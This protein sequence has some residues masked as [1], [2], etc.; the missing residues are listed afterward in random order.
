[1]A[2][3]P[4]KFAEVAQLTALGIDQS[5]M[6]WNSLTMESDKHICV[7]QEG[8]N[9]SVKISIVDLAN[10]TQVESHGINADSAIL[11]PM[12]EIIALKAETGSG[13]VLQIFN[14]KVK[15]RMKHHTITDNDKVV[16]W[17][18]IT[19]AT[20]A[21]VTNTAVYHWSME[22][23][24]KPAKVFDRDAQLAGAHILGYKIS[25]DEKW[26]SVYGIKK[27][28]TGSVDGCMQ[29]HS[30]DRNKST[31]L[32]GHCSAFATVK[33]DGAQNEVTVVAFAQ[34]TAAG[35]SQVQ[36]VEVGGGNNP[37]FPRVAGTI[38][39]ED[40]SDFPTSI[41]VS[42]KHTC[43]YMMSKMGHV[44]IYDLLTATPIFQSR[45]SESALFV[46]AN[47]EASGG[48]IGVNRNG[49]VLQIALDEANIVN[50]ICQT[51]N[52]VELAVKFA[53]RNNLPGAEGLFTRQFDALFN[54]QRFKEAA[55]C[56]A[57]SPMGVL[58]TA[59][60]IRKFQALPAT[61]G[62]SPILQYFSTLLEH[63]KLNALETVELARPA[64][65]QGKLDMLRKWWDADKLEGSEELGDM[66]RQHDNQW[67]MKIYIKGKSHSKVVAA[68]LE[69][70]QY[71]KVILYA[72]K[73]DY[74]P[75][76]ITFLR[77]MVMISPKGALDFAMKLAQNEGGSLVDIGQVVDLFMSRNLVQETTEFLLEVLKNNKPEE[78]PL[79][80]R[81]L[82]IN[83]QMAPQ[84][85]NAIFENDMFS[86]Y[87]RPH[88]ARLCEQAGLYQRALEH[89]TELSDVKRVIVHTNMIPPEVLINYFG[90][91]SAEFGLECL[92]TLL[93]TNPQGNAT[94]C[95][96][97]ATKFSEALGAAEIIPLFE[98]YNCIQGMFYYLQA[99]VNFS[100]D[101][102]VHFK[103]IQ[104]G[105]K[106][107]QLPEV[108][109][110]TRESNCYDPVAVRDFLMEAR[111]Q[112]QLPLINVCDKHDM[113]EDLVK[114]LYTNNML[115]FIQ[116]YVTDMNPMSAPKVAA[117][118]LDCDCSE[119]V[120][121]QIIT[122]VRNRCNG[123]ELV[124]EVEKRNRLKILK[125]WLE[126]VISEGNQ[127]PGVHNG[128]MKVYVDTGNEPEKYLAENLFYDS[129]D[130]GVYCEKRDPYLAFICYKRGQCD[131]ELIEVTTK[132]NLFRHQA[133]YLVERQ[134]SELWARVLDPEN[135]MR[136]N[137]IDQVISTALPATENPDD[138]S[139]TVR[140]FMAADLPGQLIE[141]LEKIVIQN[142]VFSEDPNLQ[143]LLLLTAIKAD[144]TRVMDY[145]NRL[146]KYDAPDIALIAISADLYEEAFT[147]YNKFS[148][149][150]EC[151]DVI[152]TQMTDLDRAYEYAERIDNPEVWSRLGR[153]QMQACN[154]KGAVESFCKA[155]DAQD[156]TNM[157]EQA[158]QVEAWEDLVTYLKMARSD[159]GLNKEP[160]VDTELIYALAK[161]NELAQLEE[162]INSP[163]VAQIQ[164]VG[165][166][167][168]D[169]AMY[170]AAKLLFLNISNY[171]RLAS[172]RVMLGE[173]QAA[174][175]A[176]KKAMSPRTWKEVNFA[177]VDAEEFKL[178]QVCGLHIIVHADELDDLINK[179]EHG[180]HFEQLIELMEAGTGLERAHMGIYTELGILYA[181]FKDEKLMNHIKIFGGKI[182]IPKLIRACEEYQHWLALRVLYQK[183]EEYDNA[184]TTMIMHT[185]EAFEHAVFKDII[186]KVA[187]T[188]ILYKAIKFYL[189]TV[190][191]EVNDLMATITPRVDHVRVTRLVIKEGHLPMVKEYLQSVQHNN[192]QAVNDALH[193]LYVEAGDYESVRKSVETYDNVDL[194]KLAQ[195]L[196]KHELVEFRRL[197]A[198]V[199]KRKGKYTNSVELSKADGMYRDAMET[200]AASENS[201]TCEE[202]LKFFVEESRQDCF[203][204][205]LFTMYDYLTPDVVLELA[206]RFN[207]MD[208]ALPYMVQVMREYTTRVQ[209]LEQRQEK[210]A[211]KTEDLNQLNPTPGMGGY[212]MGMGNLAL[213][214]P[215]MGP[216]GGVGMM[217]G[218]G[219]YNTGMG[220]YGGY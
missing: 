66:I 175:D 40:P 17:R 110:I 171:G 198:F 92:K 214:A 23:E 126:T 24:G 47:H 83:L 179:Y 162:L 136:Q 122:A 184:V 78:G 143:N 9:K 94:I 86:H 207:M 63:G 30:K 43:I 142:S 201:E 156:Y 79:Q 118:L 208:F 145:I 33:P 113:V 158:S 56:A 65:Q 99:V 55:Q 192:L 146:D 95:V 210:M 160:V 138:V 27:G 183:Y 205:S 204:A 37:T 87:D 16:F 18:W 187:N 166:R 125:P 165:D 181:K 151:I 42:E 116:I 25:A 199:Y 132:H 115:K 74:A 89:Y 15:V 152:I 19:P 155:K 82:E 80:T 98:Q 206:Y 159:G 69:A 211:D 185:P 53:A 202:L 119:D 8:A 46:T 217:S 180:G 134:N 5:F 97:I 76:Y 20:I 130:V 176:A 213:M 161:T 67:A 10:P 193:E 215:G 128:L 14:L 72:Q 45:I 38:R 177:C 186:T 108:E 153:A 28:P 137:L 107:G 51:L 150:Q 120:I 112:D 70:G 71:D 178:A 61:G 101:P 194:L 96:Q 157:V 103:Y 54:Q 3:L 219:Q 129:R 170:E 174:V 6:T 44:F 212:D 41:A 75:D 60:T 58:R 59:D 62:Q 7:R 196:E 123:D 144:K 26:M 12:T 102:D 52:N 13:Q 117:A 218:Q 216:M 139:E 81:L 36:V 140:A 109:R 11:N 22:G 57:E 90:K 106:L 84:V 34:K 167:C 29:L 91:L 141:L 197:A 203:A 124:A 149:H 131:D 121:Q 209:E 32:E 105:C 4:V 164:V 154:I 220:G 147:I 31:V 93:A 49:Q 104:A 68:F 73:T 50:H 64:V 111:L 48:V 173:F 188:E 1:M 39:W 77:Q 127:E 114:Y 169:A 35:Q 189:D 163:N 172:A 191:Q 168:F 182:N 85:A 148:L 135:P 21:L 100:E 190:P 2:S 88:I 195:E 133:S 200:A